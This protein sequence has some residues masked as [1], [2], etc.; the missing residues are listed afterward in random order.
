MKLVEIPQ[1]PRMLE[2]YAEELLA[3]I[4]SGRVR[5]LAIATVNQF[6]KTWTWYDLSYGDHAD[7]Y[8][9]LDDLKDRI[10]TTRADEAREED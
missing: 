5:S 3:D 2:K 10:R 8:M 9:A 1:E 7:L 4:R 6:R